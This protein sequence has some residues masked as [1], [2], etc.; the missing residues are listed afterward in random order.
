MN[1]PTMFAAGFVSALSV[2]VVIA[3]P[4]FEAGRRSLK[5]AREA[6]RKSSDLIANLEG[7]VEYLL[8]T[9]PR[10]GPRGKFVKHGGKS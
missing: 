6:L 1:D 9:A 7:Y 2:V 3:A 8:Q 5:Q 10:R 4:M